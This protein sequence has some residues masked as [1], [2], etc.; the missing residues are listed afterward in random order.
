MPLRCT[1][2]FKLV[3]L[4]GQLQVS[5]GTICRRAS[6]LPGFAVC[7]PGRSASTSTCVTPLLFHFSHCGSVL[8]NVLLNVCPDTKFNTTLSASRRIASPSRQYR[9]MSYASQRDKLKAFTPTRSTITDDVFKDSSSA[10]STVYLPIGPGFP[11]LQLSQPD[12]RTAASMIN[13]PPM[14]CL[15]IRLLISV[16]FPS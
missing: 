13:P 1:S 5:S 2:T 3:V 10:T 12:N 8:G 11:G 4:L 9:P 16:I 15:P 14:S 7:A 6:W